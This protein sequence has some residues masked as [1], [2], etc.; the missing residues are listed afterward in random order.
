M[1]IKNF[2]IVIESQI[3]GHLFFGKWRPKTKKNHNWSTNLLLWVQNL[4]ISTNIDFSSY[5]QCGWWRLTLPCKYIPVYWRR[6]RSSSANHELRLCWIVRLLKRNMLKYICWTAVTP[7]ATP[8]NNIESNYIENCMIVLFL[9]ETFEFL[10]F[11]W[12]QKYL[13]STVSMLSEQ[14]HIIS[15]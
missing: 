3:W 6:R 7:L 9:V 10:T 11:C 1:C 5:P 12:D 15:K 4:L 14:L 8:L 2:R 13:P